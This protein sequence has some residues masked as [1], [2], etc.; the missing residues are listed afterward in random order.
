MLNFLLLALGLAQAAPL[1][2]GMLGRNWG[3]APKPEDSTLC[4]V[5]VDSRL[6]RVT[7]YTC[8]EQVG[9]V[10]L[11]AMFMYLDDRLYAVILETRGPVMCAQLRELAM[12][13]WG[14]GVPS[15]TYLRGPLDN[16]HW[17]SSFKQ[18]EYIGSFLWDGVSCKLLAHQDAKQK[19]VSALYRAAVP[20]GARKGL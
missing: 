17:G 16:W 7:S 10:Y 19:E 13:A 9:T 20:V 15:S 4:A 5:F 14:K 3:S 1:S 11:S 8:P 2:E 18:P 12:G 6:P